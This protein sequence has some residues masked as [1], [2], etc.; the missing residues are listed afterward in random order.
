MSTWGTVSELSRRWRQRLA[1]TEIGLSNRKKSR[2]RKS[3]AN[4]VDG[5]AKPVLSPRGF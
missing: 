3:E 5:V 4:V 2:E 1:P